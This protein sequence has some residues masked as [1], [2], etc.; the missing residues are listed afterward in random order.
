V[1]RKAFDPEDPS[2]DKGALINNITASS[3]ETQ[4]A[5]SEFM[6]PLS[7]TRTLECLGVSPAELAE[8]CSACTHF[9]RFVLDQVQDQPALFGL[10]A[11]AL[12]KVV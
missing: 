1:A 12:P 9:I 8:L 2:H 10:T 3:K 11:E 5:G 6:L 7:S 4:Q